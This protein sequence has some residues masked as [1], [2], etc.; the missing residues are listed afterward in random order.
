MEIGVS[1]RYRYSFL[2][3]K[4]ADSNPHSRYPH[5]TPSYPVG[6]W[7]GYLTN[8]TGKETPRNPRRQNLVIRDEAG[9][10]G[11]P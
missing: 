5:H 4:P 7:G 8:H 11:K 3:P 1:Y 10:E 9:R 6:S 2:S